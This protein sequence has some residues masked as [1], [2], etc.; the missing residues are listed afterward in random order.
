MDQACCSPSTACPSL[1]AP[2]SVTM[3]TTSPSV[4][5]A[6]RRSRHVPQITQIKAC[7]PLHIDPSRITISITV[8]SPVVSARL[9]ILRLSCVSVPQVIG[10]GA[11][12][13]VMQVRQNDTGNIYA[14]KAIATRRSHPTQHPPSHLLPT[15][16]TSCHMLA[17]HLT[18]FP[19]A[20]PPAT[21]SH[22]TS[23]DTSPHSQHVL[24]IPSS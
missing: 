10:T 2:L 7:A 22:L 23:L 3:A 16:L 5:R 11:S 6:S 21:C 18:C 24:L 4:L 17:P 19:P 9:G 8:I 20:S 1:G 15:C 12:G 14:M 13:T